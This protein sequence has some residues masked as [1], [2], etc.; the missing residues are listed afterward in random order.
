VIVRR[1]ILPTTW[2]D[3]LVAGGTRAGEGTLI[4]LPQLRLA[5]EPGRMHRSLPPMRTVCLSHG[6]AD[7]IGGLCY[8]ASQRLLNGLGSG[9]L[10]VPEA[11]SE[12]V[13]SLLETCAALEGGKPYAVELRAVADGSA[14]PLR[15]DFS[16]EFFATDHWV[17]TLGSRLVWTRHRLKRNL[18]DEAPEKLARR[19]ERGESITNEVRMPLLSYSA[20]SGPGLFHRPAAV[21]AEV[22]LVECS[23]W[24]DS[25]VERARRFGH[26]HLADLVEHAPALRCRHLVLLHA[27]RR[28]RIAEVENLIGAELAPRLAAEVHHLIVDWD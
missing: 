21:D 9:E 17:P 28:N 15:K 12:T 19:R 16:L 26:M 25:D 5:L 22:M 20:D 10:F 13:A 27:S 18:A 6:H 11:I 1:L 7:H 14:V 24:N 23:F 4:L 2:G 8:W 3:L